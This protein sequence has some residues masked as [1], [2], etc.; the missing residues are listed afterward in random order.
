MSFSGQSFWV[1]GAS[2]GIGEAIAELLLERGAK[3]VVSARRREK[4]QSLAARHGE[5]VH[6]LPL[7]VTDEARWTEAADEAW[8][9]FDGLDGVIHSAGVSQRSLVRETELDVDRRIME[10][11]FFAPV[12]LTKALLARLTTRRGHV[13]VV[14][15]VAGKVGTPL[16]SAYC[17]SKHA[18]QGFFDALRNEHPEDLRVT[19]VVPGYVDTP[20]TQSALTADGSALGESSRLQAEG[21][22]A[23][24]VAQVTLDGMEN[25]KAEVLIG[26][27]ELAAVHLMRLAPSLVA[28]AVRRIKTT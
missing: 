8:S 19:I 27:R 7:D 25:G 22:S 1:T 6:V 18:V 12:G 15:S 21:V 11:N 3:V 23:R 17:A 13:V 4:L 10:L 16:R 26:G 2:S 28:R 20:I 9:A 24:A 5:R 14:S